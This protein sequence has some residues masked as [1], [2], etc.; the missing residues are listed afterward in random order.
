[1]YS[2]GNCQSRYCTNC[3]IRIYYCTSCGKEISHKC[4]DIGFFSTLNNTHICSR[5]ILNNKGVYCSNCGSKQSYCSRCGNLLPCGSYSHNCINLY[6]SG[7][8]CSNCGSK[9]SYCSEC[10]ELLPCFCERCYSIHI[11][12]KYF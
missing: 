6:G 9:N 11:C 1:M 2:Y 4:K 8:Y 7:S 12:K 5:N 3:G 10:G